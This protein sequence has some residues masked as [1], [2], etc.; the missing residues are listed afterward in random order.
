ME[1]HNAFGWY[2]YIPF[3]IL[4]FKWGNSLIDTDIFKNESDVMVNTKPKLSVVLLLIPVLIIS[5]TSIKSFLNSTGSI[6][7]VNSEQVEGIYPDVW[8]YSGVIKQPLDNPNNIYQIY[9]FNGSDLD[10]KPSFYNNNMLPTNYRL[11]SSSVDKNWNISIA[12]SPE[13]RAVILYK[14]EINNLT[15][16]NLS[17]FKIVRF[18]K[19][20][21][22]INNTK[23]HWVY[24]PCDI[25][26]ETTVDNFLKLNQ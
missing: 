25:N 21:H 24:L 9:H 8:F 26:C 20:L 15:Y 5:S 14:Y 7:T 11:I 2:I 23:L 19:A 18:T 1:D 22:N 4:L 3:M 6:Q 12:Q 13:N 16:T 17:A 10:G